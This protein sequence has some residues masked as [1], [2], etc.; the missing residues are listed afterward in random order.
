MKKLFAFT[1]LSAFLTLSYAQDELFYAKVKKEEV[2][3][4]VM[5]AVEQDFPD[6]SITTLKAL[7]VEIIDQHWFIKTNKKDDAGEDYDTY[8]M[9]VKTSKG[10]IDAIYD[11]EG[12]LIYTTE[13]LKNVAL[14][15]PLQKTIGRVFPGWAVAG[16][17]ALVT[18][19]VD[20]R[21]K[22]HYIIDLSKGSQHEHIV[23]DGAGNLLKSKLHPEEVKTQGKDKRKKMKKHRG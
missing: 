21:N 2:P 14:P 17:K 5:T 20:G 23:L 18:H 8:V 1:L 13:H 16:D 4:V 3:A 7:P 6:G 19:F 12:N 15:L 22:A 10:M 11:R 9:T